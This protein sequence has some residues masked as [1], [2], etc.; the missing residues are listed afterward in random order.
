MN[1]LL[2]VVQLATIPASIFL[3]LLS[4]SYPSCL[5]SFLSGYP[6]FYKQK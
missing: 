5:I 4:L 2:Y 6:L 3:F 1:P